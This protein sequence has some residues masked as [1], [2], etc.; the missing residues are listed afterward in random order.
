MDSSSLIRFVSPKPFFTPKETPRRTTN[1]F[2]EF[3]EAS[4]TAEDP[5]DPHQ[6]SISQ[7]LAEA[8]SQ[9]NRGWLAFDPYDRR[10]EK[11]LDQ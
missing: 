7:F 5:N 2:H 1:C 11:A 10:E 8:K 6:R 3:D 4:L 9:A